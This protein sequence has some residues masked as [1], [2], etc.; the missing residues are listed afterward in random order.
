MNFSRSIVIVS[1]VAL[2]ALI[3]E[4]MW[5]IRRMS[6]YQ[7]LGIGVWIGVGVGG[8]VWL[9]LMVLMIAS[10]WKVFVKAGKPGWAAIV[11]LHNLIVMLEIVGKPPWYIALAFVPFAN[12][13]LSIGLQF[14]MAKSFGKGMGFGFG[15]LFL[16]P[17]FYPLLAF[18]DAQYTGAPAV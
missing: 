15:L 17:V 10:M 1:V 7:Q 8:V 4:A 11:P 18:G 12:I 3:I 13:Y 6:D 9:A 5:R 16:A 14:W 2:L